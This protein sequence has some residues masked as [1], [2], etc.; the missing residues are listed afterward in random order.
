MAAT[1]IAPQV[2]TRAGMTLTMTTVDAVNGNCFSNNGRRILRFTNTSGADV[3]A[4]VKFGRTIDGVSTDAGKAITIPQ[5]SGDIFTSVWPGDDYN[6]PDGT[7]VVTFS[8]G[9]NVQMAVIE[10]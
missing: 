5:T 10:V 2:P 6:Q 7:V 4:T 8:A 3:T 1:Q 9:T